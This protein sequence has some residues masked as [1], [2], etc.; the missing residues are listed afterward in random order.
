M[1]YSSTLAAVW[2]MG[3]SDVFNALMHNGHVAG[4]GRDIGADTERAQLTWHVTPDLVM[5]P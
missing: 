4:R 1:L 3:T 2:V 5:S